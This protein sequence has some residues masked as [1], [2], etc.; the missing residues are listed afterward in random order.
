MARDESQP[1]STARPTNGGWQILPGWIWASVIVAGLL[2]DYRALAR[3]FDATA[4]LQAS[5]EAVAYDAQTGLEGLGL[6]VASLL[7]FH[8]RDRIRRAIGTS[9][10]WAVGIPLMVAS[11]A[12]LVQSNLSPVTQLQMPALILNLASLALILGGMPLLRAIGMPL[13]ALVVVVPI[14]AIL[15]HQILFPLQLLTATLSSF[16]LDLVGREHVVL[17][18]LIVT[19]GIVFQVV[20]GCSGLK[21][22]MTLLLA[23]VALADFVAND[24]IEK[25][26][27]I[28]AA[29][30]VALA[31]NGVRVLALVL[32]EVP[33]E[34]PE[35]TVYGLLVTVLGVLV[36]SGL[37]WLVALL[38]SSEMRDEPWRAASNGLVPPTRPNA[39]TRRL[40][41]L[42]TWTLCTS[43]VLAI[44]PARSPA[45]AKRPSLNIE[46]L[47]REIDGWTARNLRFD[48][49]LLGSV[50]F[51]HRIHRI[52]ERDGAAIRVFVGLAEEPRPDQSSF[53]PKT[54]IP[55][56]G[57]RSIEQTDGWETG[58]RDFE[59]LTISY[60]DAKVM[61][62]HYRLGFA[63]WGLE[64][65]ASWL[66]IQRTHFGGD[67]QPLV[68]RVDRDLSP[69][70]SV[71]EAVMLH[72]F[73]RKILDWY[74]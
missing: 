13:L 49:R 33:P 1:T 20:E 65:L 52:Y 3:S 63:P 71:R 67:S 64:L 27:V 12:L 18:D 40:A 47:P 41:L 72:R 11:F 39:W 48:N 35:H 28:L 55:R 14:P 15:L 73:A 34:S 30:F 4:N 8:R 19:N 68:I 10:S 21:S 6:L 16:L 2:F 32:R 23:A 37:Q 31:A 60:P 58:V 46:E 36:L 53:S 22:T 54:R 70:H 62:D 29:P 26:V 50:W 25:A 69:Q 5:L 17:G 7:A 43:I 66:G 44:L 74:R 59:T 61:V 57:W 24:P 42:A 51:R 38:R 56:S 9:G 45:T